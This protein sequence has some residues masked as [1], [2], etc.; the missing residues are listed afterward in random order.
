MD[1]CRRVKWPRARCNQWGNGVEP[2]RNEEVKGYKEAIA[3]G[4]FRGNLC[5]KDLFTKA[6]K[7]VSGRGS[8]KRRNHLH[9]HCTC[10]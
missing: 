6:F 3:P 9:F 7:K 1:H 10:T 2:P 8:S 4:L 5:R